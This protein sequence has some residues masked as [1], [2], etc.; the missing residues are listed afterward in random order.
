MATFIAF[1]IVSCVFGA[2]LLRLHDN[3]FGL[4]KPLSYATITGGVSFA[5]VVLFPIGLIAFM[6]RDVILGIIF[7]RAVGISDPEQTKL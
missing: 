4:L 1:G 5:A 6:V 3:L 7:F 2:V